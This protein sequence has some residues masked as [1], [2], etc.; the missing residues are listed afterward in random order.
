MMLRLILD[1]L[2]SPSAFDGDPERAAGNQSAHVMLAAA[3]SSTVSLFFPY[4]TGVF[5]A[6]SAT[7]AWEAVQLKFY[8]A[9]ARDAAADFGFF[10]V[11]AFYAGPPYWP[12]VAVFFLAVH[13]MFRI[14]K[15]V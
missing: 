3:L 12:M 4:W 1:A 5:W 11:G 10:S 7:A 9:S 13:V 15:N 14:E 2:R 6:L 8:G